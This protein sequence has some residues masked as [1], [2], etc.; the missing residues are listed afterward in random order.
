MPK[1]KFFMCQSTMLWKQAEGFGVKLF[2][3]LDPDITC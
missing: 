2:V 3:I 1:V